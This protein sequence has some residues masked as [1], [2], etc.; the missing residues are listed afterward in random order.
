[1]RFAG[2]RD[3]ATDAAIRTAAVAER[4]QSE[5]LLRRRPDQEDGHASPTRPGGR[6]L[7]RRRHVL[8]RHLPCR[9]R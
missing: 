1:M 5:L 9:S 3:G 4:R 7:H 2:R 6:L 8:T